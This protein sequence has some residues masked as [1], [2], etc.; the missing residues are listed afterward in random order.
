M[1][2][3]RL[4]GKKVFIQEE[5]GDA[6]AADILLIHGAGMNHEL[7]KRSL[8]PLARAGRRVFA[9]DLPGHGESKGPALET[10]A[11]MADL[12]VRVIAGL[13]LK[14]PRLAGHSM[15]SL[16]ALE[17]TARLAWEVEGLALLGFVPE[18][19]VDAKL[20]AEAK[21]EPEA[22]A[23]R[24]LRAS[25]A[26]TSHA[27]MFWNL[28]M[29]APDAFETDLI[30]CNEYAGADTAARAVRCPTLLLLGEKDRLT[31]A[32][33]GRLFIGKFADARLALLPEA[34]HLMI[35]EEP[36]VTRAAMLT[37]L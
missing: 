9:I 11:E 6:P 14:R 24:L 28:F 8:A 29:N 22:A 27:P 31:P 7:W 32:A 15:G 10:I 4:D 13:G 25:Y 3:L 34:G 17:A 33:Q 5:I 19:R 36:E 37:V 23:R 26:D 1:A 20:I 35:L 2:T 12:V 18:M 21:R 16:V 30:A